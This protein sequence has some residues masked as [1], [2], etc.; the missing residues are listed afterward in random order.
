MARYRRNRC[1]LRAL[2]RFREGLRMSWAFLQRFRSWP[3]TTL[4]AI[5]SRLSLLNRLLAGETGKP[6]GSPAKFHE[7]G[8]DNG[9]RGWSDGRGT[10][11][12]PTRHQCDMGDYRGSSGQNEAGDGY[13]SDFRV[14]CGLC[15]LDATRPSSCGG[16]LAPSSF[17]CGCSRR[18][19]LSLERRSARRRLEAGAAFF[20]NTFWIVIFDPE[21]FG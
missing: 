7:D 19:Y 1:Q 8:S 21:G 3:L 4:G 20:V 6:S 11:R 9:C 2:A 16:A 5:E 12:Q 15:G 17:C 10:R 13:D 18:F 14:G